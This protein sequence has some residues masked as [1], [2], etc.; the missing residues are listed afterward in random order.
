M[1]HHYA[2][3]HEPLRAGATIKA[4][5]GKEVPQAQ[6][7]AMID[8]AQAGDKFVSVPAHGLCRKCFALDWDSHRFLYVVAS[9]QEA[10]EE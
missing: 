10:I 5:C 3:A 4:M 1:K 8:L 7:A 9:G 6:F 2:I